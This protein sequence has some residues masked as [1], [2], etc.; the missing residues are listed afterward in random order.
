MSPSSTARVICSFRELQD[1]GAC[2]VELI[3]II[4]TVVSGAAGAGG[5]TLVI[6]HWLWLRFCRHVYDDAVAHNEKPKPEEIIRA[7]SEGFRVRS[8]KRPALP[9]SPKSDDT[10]LAA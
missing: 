7:A 1:H 9:S 10:S 5:A 6:R 2:Q 8:P 4:A 3:P